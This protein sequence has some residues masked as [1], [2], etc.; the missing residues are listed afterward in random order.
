[1]GGTREEYDER[2][3]T[4]DDERSGSRDV[5]NAHPLFQTPCETVLFKCIIGDLHPTPPKHTHIHTH[6]HTHTH[7]HITTTT[8]NNNNNNNKPTVLKGERENEWVRDRQTDRRT[9][10][11][12]DRQTDRERQRQTE[13]ERE[14]Q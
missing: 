5:K 2:G 7:T 8:N 13:R 12:K 3:T 6:T 9:D 10:R 1:M 14:Y 11:R 4:V